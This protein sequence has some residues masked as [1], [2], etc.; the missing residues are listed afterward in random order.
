M[1]KR[2]VIFDLDG[3]LLDTI[4]DLG[5]AVNYALNA[6]GFPTHLPESYPLL[7]G[8]GARKL[9][10]RA[11][12][13]DSCNQEIIDRLL[14]DFKLYYSDHATANT[15]PYPGIPEL[16]DTLQNEGVQIAV[17]SNKYQEAVTSLIR[18]FFPDINF[19]A[20]LGQRDNMPVKPDPSIVFNIILHTG[21]PKQETLYVG[22]SGVDM[23]TAGRACV[24]SVGVTWG[25]RPIEELRQNHATYIA[26]QPAD[27]LNIVNNRNLE[28]YF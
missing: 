12:P 15:T 13:A 28:K 20:V 27:I 25:F 2:L 23:L 26:N 14:V 22:D 7:V 17:A 21:V 11:L 1:N 4:N 5:C 19:T 9:I 18:H 10:E 16:L 24:D 3:T 6:N 8:N